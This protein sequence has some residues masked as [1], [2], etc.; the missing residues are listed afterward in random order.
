MTRELIV[1]GGGVNGLVTAAYLAKAG[2]QVLVLEARGTP[3]GLAATDEIMPGFRSSVAGHDIGW[4]LPDIAAHLK[5]G[6][7]GLELVVPEASVFSPLPEGRS[8]TLWTDP[9]RAAEE[10]ARFSPEDA[11]RWPPFTAQ[12]A[13]FARLLEATYAVTPPRIPDA[14]GRDVAT[15][16][17]LGRRL[18][19]L[20]RREMVEFLRVAPMS[21]AEWLDDWFATDALK[22]AVGAGG[23][24]RILQGPRSA[25]TAFVL[26]HHQVGRPPGAVRGAHLVKGGLEVLARTL[27]DVARGYGAEIRTSAPV[28]EIVVRDG[29]AIGVALETGE[30]IAARR[31]V[32]SADP[33]RTL[34]GLVPAAHL[35]PEFVRAINNIRFRGAVATVHLALGELPRFSS[36]PPEGAL[37]GAITIAPS[38]DYL[39]RA[40]DDAKYGGVS[41]HPYLEARIPTVLDPGLAPPGRHLMS[42]QVQYAPYQLRAGAWDDAA[43]DRLADSV[44]ATLAAHAPNIGTSVLARHDVTPKDLEDRF[45]LTEGHPYHGEMTLDQIV[46]MRPVAGWA[47]YRTPIKG[48]FLCGAGTHPGGGLAGAPGR[49]AARELLLKEGGR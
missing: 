16:F 38:L 43:R 1:I 17:G 36:R 33:R 19:R 28:R 11:H 22:G 34:C 45:G 20:G 5:L 3:G 49:N 2:I 14:R 37:R 44:V 4:L 47:R 35:D 6:A 48:L 26:L 25:G 10:I 30:H 18:R 7:A 15:L 13:R 31:V 8:L 23:V 27:A 41:R 9:A 32:S 39:E 40:Y 12:L 21:V 42:V 24:T 46:F 29:R